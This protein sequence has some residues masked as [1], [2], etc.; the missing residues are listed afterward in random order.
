MAKYQEKA[1]A[2]EV[3][4]AII[5]ASIMARLD[6]IKPPDDPQL[7]FAEEVEATL[8]TDEVVRTVPPSFENWLAQSTVVI[9]PEQLPSALRG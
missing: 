1:I 4:F 5:N 8:P 6:K 3:F 2:C 9:T 7:F